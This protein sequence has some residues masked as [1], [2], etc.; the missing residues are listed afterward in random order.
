M[1]IQEKIKSK[2]EVTK[3]FYSKYEKFIPIISFFSG[4]TWDSVTLTRIDQLSDNLIIL[5]YILLLGAA[6]VFQAF[7]EKGLITQSLMVK[8]SEW[9]PAVIQFFLGGLFSTYVVFYFQS[10]SFTKTALFLI[11]LIGLLIANEFLHKRLTNLYLVLSLYFLAAFSFFI[12]F[13]P[14]ITEVMNIWTFLL[15]GFFSLLFVGLIVWLFAKKQI[16]DTQE[17]IIRHSGLVLG[18]YLLLNLFYFF[19]WIPP[20]P[21]SMK[22]TGIYHNVY[23]DEDSYNLK[24]EKPEWYQLFKSDDKDF[25]YVEGD[26]A[27]CFAAVFA[28]TNLDKKILHQWQFYSEKEGEWVTSDRRGYE[29]HGGREGGYRGYTYKKNVKPGE[30]RVNII[31]EDDLLLGR[32]EFDI[33]DSKETSREWEILKK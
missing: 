15:G 12:F 28:P 4:F 6:I 7:T 16:F 24:Q 18:L 25:N 32:I 31:T 23:R 5:L 13:L 33:T 19:N 27:Y 21:L 3:S 10:A 30:W 17:K 9:Y 8:Y 26:T 1:E 20:V 2:I 29:L 11:L 22:Y 14:M